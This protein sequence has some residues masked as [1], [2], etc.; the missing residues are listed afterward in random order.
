MA[1]AKQKI[2]KW[3]RNV[4]PAQ[5]VCFA[6]VLG[7]SWSLSSQLARTEAA[8]D[9]LTARIER[10]EDRLDRM[11]DRTWQRVDTSRTEAE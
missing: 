1:T 6:A 5:A 10:V 11:E 3:W 7:A 4:T 2:E 8:V 9:A